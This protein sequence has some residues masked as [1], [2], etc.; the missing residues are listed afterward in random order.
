MFKNYLKI[1]L[2]NLLRYKGYSLINIVGLAIGITC[3]IMIFLFVQDEMSFDNFHTKSDRLYRLNKKVTPQT[4]GTEWHAITPGLMGPTMVSDFPE[5]EQSLRLLPWFDDVLMTRG[6]TSLKLSNV[7]F[8]DSNFF[9]IFD[10]RLLQGNAKT[11][12]VEPLSIILS[13]KTAG[14]FFGNS[15]PIGQVIQGLNDLSY[16]V[17]G[18]IEETPANSSLRYNALISWTSTI[19]GTGP[20]NW[21]WLN[22]WI[23]QVNFT[24]LLLFPETDV[25]AFEKKLADFMVK[26]MPRQAE[27]YKLYLQPLADIYLKS[28]QIRFNDSLLMGNITTVYIFSAIALLTLLIACINFTNLSTARATK[29]AREVG[30]RKVLGAERK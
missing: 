5:V 1:S 20:L 30:I 19:P 24:Y 23:T 10:F 3:T 4:G 22:R 6:E 25:P 9:D 16:K 11:A 13:E 17:T 27:Y 21:S 12:L 7:V 18:I 15:D 2:R 29:R 14:K 8:A 26:Y 28:S